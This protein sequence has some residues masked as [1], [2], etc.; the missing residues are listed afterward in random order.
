MVLVIFAWVTDFNIIRT[1]EATCGEMT[2][3]K[4]FQWKVRIVYVRFLS[5]KVV[6]KPPQV[7]VA[8]DPVMNFLS[9]SILS[10]F[11]TIGSF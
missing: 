11:S 2:Y 7:L 6:D 8:Y 10:E 4:S 5:G 1:V 3:N 9:V